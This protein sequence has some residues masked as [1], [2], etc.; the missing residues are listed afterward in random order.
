MP[1]LTESEADAV[2]SDTDHEV[3]KIDDEK[4]EWGGVKGDFINGVVATQKLKS[5][6][7]GDL[8]NA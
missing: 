2:A 1:V 3:E 5:G 8:H 4:D 7:N 6:S